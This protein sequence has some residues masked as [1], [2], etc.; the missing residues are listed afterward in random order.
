MKIHTFAKVSWYKNERHSLRR[1]MNR[2]MPIPVSYKLLDLGMNVKQGEARDLVTFQ[3]KSSMKRSRRELSIGM[4][5]EVSS[6]IT[7]LCSSS[8]LPVYLEQVWDYL[9]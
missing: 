3:G 2:G 4:E 7:R 1:G 9:K 6:K 8:Y 5:L